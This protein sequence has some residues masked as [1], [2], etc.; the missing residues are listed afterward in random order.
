MAR[1]FYDMRESRSVRMSDCVI[2]PVLTLSLS[3]PLRVAIYVSCLS[4]VSAA[5]QESAQETIKNI[6][7]GV[8]D[9]LRERREEGRRKEGMKGRERG[10]TERKKER[11]TR[12][13]V[14]QAKISR[15]AASPLFFVS[16]SVEH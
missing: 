11:K 4:A 2:Q 8:H 7:I 5:S 3:T 13:T 9:L 10:R 12:K 14:G 16:V 6:S 15:T 1:V